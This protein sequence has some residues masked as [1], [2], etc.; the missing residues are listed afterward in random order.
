MAEEEEPQ[1][2]HSGWGPRPRGR[3]G[4]R[5]WQRLGRDAALAASSLCQYWHTAVF[6]D[7]FQRDLEEGGE[8]RV[9]MG[10]GREYRRQIS[11]IWKNHEFLRPWWRM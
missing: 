3:K 5:R 10:S 2:H 11:L 6:T 9:I 8:V 7:F 1:V 4:A